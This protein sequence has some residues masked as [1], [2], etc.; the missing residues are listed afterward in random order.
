[1]CSHQVVSGHPAV[2]SYSVTERLE[3]FW[4]YLS[5]L[6]VQVRVWRE[7]E[8]GRKTGRIVDYLFDSGG[9]QAALGVR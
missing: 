5:A 4:Q 8:E 7:K 9:V 1:M 6:G 3:P 2:L